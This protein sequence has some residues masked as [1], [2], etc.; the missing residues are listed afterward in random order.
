MRAALRDAGL[1]LTAVDYVNAHG[2]GTVLSDP[3][4]TRSIRLALGEHADK[5]A[6]SSTK[7][8]HATCS[9]PLARSKPPFAS[10]AIERGVVPP[11]INLE[12]PDPACDTRLRAGPRPRSAR[13]TSR[14]RT[15]WRSADTT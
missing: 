9:A 14:S 7:S 5:V 10:L 3:A 13:S 2:T 8:M 12:V 11:T 6:V 15:R 1:E 4:E